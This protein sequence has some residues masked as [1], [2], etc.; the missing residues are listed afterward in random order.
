[1]GL[2]KMDRFI[3]DL[4]SGTRLIILPLDNVRGVAGV[5]ITHTM[6]DGTEQG[7]EL[8]LE[9]ADQLRGGL[10]FFPRQS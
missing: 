6:R 5:S 1:M 7:M 9:E 4:S 3:A 10:L 2:L 8:T